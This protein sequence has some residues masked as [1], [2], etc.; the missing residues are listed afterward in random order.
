MREHKIFE[1]I[2]PDTFFLLQTKRKAGIA[3]ECSFLLADSSYY[4]VTSD[5]TAFGIFDTG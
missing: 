3:G 4:V 1:M 2:Y 5:Y